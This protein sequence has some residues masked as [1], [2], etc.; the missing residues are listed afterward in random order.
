M[1]T[2]RK[3]LKYSRKLNSGIQGV[4]RFLSTENKMHRNFA[5]Y[6]L[7]GAVNFKVLCVFRVVL[8]QVYNER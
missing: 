1:L 8:L 7:K 2:A 5:K 3:Y 6:R 4:S